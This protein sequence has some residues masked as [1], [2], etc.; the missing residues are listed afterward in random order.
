MSLALREQ[1]LPTYFTYTSDFESPF[2][3]RGQSVKRPRTHSASP[4]PER[5]KLFLKGILLKEKPLAI[6]EDE[7]GETYIRSIGENVLEQE[8]LKIQEN[9]VVLR[10]RRG[11]YEIVVQEK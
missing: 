7:R 4:V 9:K 3:K 5:Q 2:R 10:D 11:T 1:E 8:I 6:I